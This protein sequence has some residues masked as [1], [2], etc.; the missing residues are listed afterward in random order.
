[1]LIS[2]LIEKLFKLRMDHGDLEVR[3]E[4]NTDR[5]GGSTEYPNI[6]IYQMNGKWLID[7]GESFISISEA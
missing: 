1:M 6:D 2:E 3:I 4:K 7:S 5:Y